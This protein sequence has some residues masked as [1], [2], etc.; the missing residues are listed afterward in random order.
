MIKAAQLFAALA[1]HEGQL[2]PGARTRWAFLVTLE[3]LSSL[4]D[5]FQQHPEFGLEMD[6]QYAADVRAGKAALIINGTAVL[7]E[8]LE[9]TKLDS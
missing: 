7:P 9:G 8:L 6:P 3:E 1:Q 5:E 2:P 4:M